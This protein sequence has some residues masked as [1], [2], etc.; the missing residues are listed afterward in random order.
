M[1][2][3]II[4]AEDLLRIVTVSAG[5]DGSP[6][7]LEALD[8]PLSD[9]GYDS[10]A[11]LETVSRIEREY[12]VGLDESVASADLTLRQLLAAVHEAA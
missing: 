6:L 7:G 1:T 11:L 4:T 12:G 8:I 3:S 10:L 5:V 9:L 2:T